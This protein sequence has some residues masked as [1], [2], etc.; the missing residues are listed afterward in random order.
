M[1]LGD[2]GL[3][4]Q[5]REGLGVL[6]QGGGGH[7]WIRQQY[8]CADTEGVSHKIELGFLSPFVILISFVDNCL[9]FLVF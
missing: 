4:E 6:Q 7:G 5:A 2:Y 8:G 9:Y 3:E 1:F